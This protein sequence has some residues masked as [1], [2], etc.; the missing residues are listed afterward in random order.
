MKVLPQITQPYKNEE[1]NHGNKK[2][3]IKHVCSK[4]N[5]KT[6]QKMNIW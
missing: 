4:L 2:S 3:S 1:K 6:K 5:E